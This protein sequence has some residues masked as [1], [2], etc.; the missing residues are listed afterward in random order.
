MSILEAFAYGKPV[1][2]SDLGAMPCLVSHGENGM[3]FAPGDA[4]ALAGCVRGMEGDGAKTGSM[5]T[6]ARER[7]VADYGPQKNFDVLARIYGS[8]MR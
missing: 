7:A 1:I 5:G 2:A 3:L 8:V 6:A 4:S